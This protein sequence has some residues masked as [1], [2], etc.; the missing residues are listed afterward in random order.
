M[1][2]TRFRT[3]DRTAHGMGR[4]KGILPFGPFCVNHREVVLESLEKLS[5]V[6][7]WSVCVEKFPI[8]AFVKFY[9]F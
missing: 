7:K 8:R 6:V 2:S 3:S 5:F 1:Y 4:E 9:V